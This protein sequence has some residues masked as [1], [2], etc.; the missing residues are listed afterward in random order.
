M[1]AVYGVFSPDRRKTA[2]PEDEAEVK[3]EPPP[4]QSA[5]RVRYSIGRAHLRARNRVIILLG[6]RLCYNVLSS[7]LR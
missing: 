5:G 1:T 7:P 6:D 3:S 2:Y 4:D